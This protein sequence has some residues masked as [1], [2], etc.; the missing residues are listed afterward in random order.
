M[1]GNI[2]GPTRWGLRTRGIGVL[3]V[4]AL[5]LAGAWQI[6]RPDRDGQIQFA[7]RAADLGDG[8]STDTAVRLRGL[9]IGSVVEVRPEGPKEQVVTLSVDEERVRELSTAMNTRFVSSNVF[10]ST[11]L[12]LI[13]MPGGEAI[14]PG[15]VLDLGEVGDYTVTTILRDSGRLLLDVV[16][17]ELSDSIDSSVELTEQMAPVLASALLVARTVARAR[18][19]SLSELLPKLADVSE[20]TAVF[21]PAALSTLHALA[22]VE[23][24]D[25]DFRTRQAGETITEV[26]N[27]V[28]ALSG[29]V[30]GALGP[31]S[32]VVD[33]LLDLI[34]PLNRSLSG[35]TPEQVDRLI[36]GLGGALY[37]DG[38]RVVLGVDVLVETFPAFRMP[39]ELTGGGR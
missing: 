15:A 36:D 16:T 34:I 37:R 1:S 4:T 31:T 8:V 28:L 7:V 22:S 29:N 27:L 12:E 19:M 32:E 3:V 17:T 13:P 33:M 21:T 38:D 5:V 24:L 2:H 20:G 39:L 9:S 26:S 35:V 6:T 25:D 14:A 10:G 23:E 18:N 11:A 30:V